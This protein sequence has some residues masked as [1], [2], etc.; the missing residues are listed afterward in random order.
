[1]IRSMTGFGTA[2]GMVAGFKVTVEIRS[3]NSKF[4]ELNMRLPN[5]FRDREVDLRAEISKS[6]ERGKIDVAI[7]FDN[8]EMAR[9]SSV[10]REMFKAYYEEL[11]ALSTELSLNENNW[12]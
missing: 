11:K 8:N 1:M 4:F 12:T 3:L 5:L 10:N 7:N 2:S 9:K 6:A